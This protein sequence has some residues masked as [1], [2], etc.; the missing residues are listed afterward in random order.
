MNTLLL[1]LAQILLQ[2]ALPR[3]VRRNLPEA[4]DRIDSQIPKLLAD[5][6][7]PAALYAVT[8]HALNVVSG[9]HPSPVTVAVTTM[10]WDYLKAAGK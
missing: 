6:A 9:E 10:V 8:A 1:K 4:L 3:Q 7:P 5:K 2:L